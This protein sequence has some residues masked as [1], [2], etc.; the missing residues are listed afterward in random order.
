MATPN[1]LAAADSLLKE[2]YTTDE[3]VAEYQRKFPLLSRLN[4]SSY[5]G[6]YFVVPILTS[7]GAGVA[8]DLTNASATA[9]GIGSIDFNINVAD[10][11][12]VVPLLSKTRKAAKSGM[13]TFLDYVKKEMDA[14]L[15][16]IGRAHSHQLFGDG[17]GVIGA[18][19]SASGNVI[20]LSDPKDA[21]NFW[22]DMQIV[23]TDAAGT[24]AR[25]GQA[26]VVSKDP[27]A[28]T[29]TVD[30]IAGIS[31][32]ANTDKM[33]VRGMSNP[34]LASTTT[35][36]TGLG[37][38]ITAAAPTDTLF[39]VARTTY[40]E[41]GGIRCPSSLQVGGPVERLQNLATFM[42]ESWQSTPTLG[43]LHPTKWNTASKGLQA[44]GFRAIKVDET[45]AMAGYM[46]LSIACEGGT[47]EIISDPNCP[48]TVGYLLDL[49]YM[50]LHHYGESMI[51]IDKAPTGEYYVPASSYVGHEVRLT[52]FA[53]LCM[54]A[55]WKH[56]RVTI[57]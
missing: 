22:R 55:P 46:M 17:T 42:N 52:S 3:I 2:Y 6:K 51:E 39:G 37:R 48:Q 27:E 1:D 14:K 11:V 36:M 33:Y 53:N 49:E 19:A 57:A 12:G 50:W 44:Q 16:G 20:T 25:T 21:I 15:L 9:K 23:A 56:G 7:D 29:V 45:R 10:Y 28:G 13:G 32:F 8:A 26:T 41:L 30:N 40:P 4:K 31:S 38:W 54:N 47:M 24:T 34:T 43:V 18:R 35:V 5:E